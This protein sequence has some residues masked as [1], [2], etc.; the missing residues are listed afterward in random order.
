MRGG[1]Q[2][3]FRWAELTVSTPQLPEDKRSSYPKT[4]LAVFVVHNKLKTK[5]GTLP[6]DVKYYAGDNVRPVTIATISFAAYFV[7]PGKI[8]SRSM[9]LVPLGGIV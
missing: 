3:F 2:V 5:L 1:D 4:E 8:G 9:D 6:D 7:Y